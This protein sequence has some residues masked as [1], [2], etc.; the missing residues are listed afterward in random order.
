MDF[1]TKF[2][3]TKDSCVKVTKVLRS[4]VYSTV[5]VLTSSINL[6]VYIKQ[7]KDFET[8]RIAIICYNRLCEVVN[9]YY[10]RCETLFV[11]LVCVYCD[12]DV[13]YL[14][15]ALGSVRKKS[16]E[17]YREHVCV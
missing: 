7:S 4:F 1:V 17:V 12:C 8:M 10:A 11:S 2:L 9:I 6:S 15:I 5:L 13:L 3:T 16:K 14:Y